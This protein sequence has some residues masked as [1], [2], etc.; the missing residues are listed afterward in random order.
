MKNRKII[1]YFLPIVFQMSRTRTFT[2][3]FCFFYII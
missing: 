3:I 2:N 1:Y